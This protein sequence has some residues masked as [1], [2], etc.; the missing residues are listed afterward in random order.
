M[1]HDYQPRGTQDLDLRDSLGRI[2]PR[3][4]TCALLEE[5][6]RI[7]LGCDDLGGVGRPELAAVPNATDLCTVPREK[8]ARREGMGL[9]ERGKIPLGI[10]VCVFGLSM[11]N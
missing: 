7:E 10:R 11:L 5:I 2:V 3:L 8:A 9:A 1:A 6:E 4:Q